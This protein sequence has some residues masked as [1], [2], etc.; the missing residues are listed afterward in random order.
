M[1]SNSVMTY[2]TAVSRKSANGDDW[3]DVAGN[4]GDHDTN[5][6]GISDRKSV[7]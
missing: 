1:A 2:L 5:Q 6:I 4:V 7:V 3:E